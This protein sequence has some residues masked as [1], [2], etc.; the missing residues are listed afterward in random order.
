MPAEPS[1]AKLQAILIKVTEALAGEL[2]HPGPAAPDWS[3][4][5]WRMAQAASAMHG[6][7][8]LLRGVL[9]WEGPPGWTA[10]LWEQ[11]AH[12]RARHARIEELQS[13]LDELARSQDL[14]VVA[15]KGAALHTEGF[16]RGGERPMADLDLLVHPRD[17]HR[18]ARM[19]ESLGYRECHRSWKERAFA[20]L[21]D[22]GIARLGEHSDN[23][24]TI[25]LHERICEKLPLRI[26][27]IT[28]AVYP[29]QP[30]PGLNPYPSRAALMLHLLLHAAASM[31]FKT[32]RLIQLHDLSLLAARMTPEEWVELVSQPAGRADPWWA[33]P[34]LQLM[35]R[36]YGTALPRCAL[37]PLISSCP[38][39]L[40][41]TALRQT[42]SDVSLSYLWVD[43]LPGLEWSQSLGAMLSYARSRVWPDSEHMALRRTLLATAPWAAGH[44]WSG[45]SQ[46]R[47][48]VSWVTRRQTR[49][50]AM[51]AVR[52]ALARIP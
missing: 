28:P 30:A 27:D 32:L 35:S 38:V 47:R 48:I 43:A 19:I 33:L 16:Y 6:V 1:P 46:V 22:T 20:P 42:L 29:G 39:H 51:F 3:D 50:A 2:V 8:P 18:A 24:I 44:S 5:E 37:E 11:L 21:A 13:R 12:V 14:A 31:A 41:R 45:R 7:S 15:L 26:S 52:A 25:E 40:R 49:P 9:R 36:Y 34:P 17:G 4:L 10:F 23:R